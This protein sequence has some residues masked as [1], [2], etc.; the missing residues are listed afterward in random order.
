MVHFV[1]ILLLYPYALSCLNVCLGVVP[2]M[3]VFVPLGMYL[4][5]QSILVSFLWQAKQPFH[6]QSLTYSGSKIEFWEIVEGVQVP[7]ADDAKKQNPWFQHAKLTLQHVPK[8]YKVHF[9]C[10]SCKHCKSCRELLGGL[11][12]HALVF[13]RVCRFASIFN[14]AWKA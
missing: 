5:Q 8:T 3:C 12:A 13:A 6:A 7:R 1:G 4:G 9:H 11:W 10:D 14:Q 2:R